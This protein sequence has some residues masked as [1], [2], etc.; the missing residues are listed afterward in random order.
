MLVLTRRPGESVVVGHEVTITVLEVRQDQV[1]IGVDAPR[2]VTIHRQEVYDQIVRENAGAVTSADA[3]RKLAEQGPGAGGRPPPRP[4]T[5][6]G[7]KPPP[8]Q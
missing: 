3:A 2:S 5:P 6:R 7:D 8:D 1:R 4:G